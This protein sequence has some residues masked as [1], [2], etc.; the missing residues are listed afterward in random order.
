MQRMPLVS[1]NART[2]VQQLRASKIREVA[3]AGMERKDVAAF[4]FGE[5]DE[6]TPGF[7]RQAGKDA[8]D[9][10]ETSTR[11]TSASRSCGDR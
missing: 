5:P 10:G 6:V 2:A 3:N 7:I 4:W 8:L 1:P 11:T 9:A